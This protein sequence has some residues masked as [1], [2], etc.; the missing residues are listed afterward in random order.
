MTTRNPMNER[1]QQDERTGKTRRSAASAKPVSKAAATTAPPRK[2]TRKEKKAEQKERERKQ[3]EKMKKVAGDGFTLPT[4]QYRY[5]RRIW[6]VM[7][8]VAIVCVAL[9][10]WLSNTNMVV[11]STVFLIIGYAAIIFALWI[12]LGKIRKLRGANQAKY[13]GKSK[14]ARA[15]QKQRHQEYV[16]A[17]RESPEAGQ[18]VYRRQLDEDSEKAAGVASWS[19]IKQVFSKSDKSK[20]KA[21][22]AE[23]GSDAKTASDAGEAKKSK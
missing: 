23:T 17:R 3:E 9:S 18:E 19:S 15:A 22:D 4:K 20:K 5:W 11:P 13:R 2:K 8:V 10:W 1:Y 21:D 7:L 16:E 12:D 14:A 6:W